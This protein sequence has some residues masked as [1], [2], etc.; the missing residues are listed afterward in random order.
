V[1]FFQ[2]PLGCRPHSATAP[3][4]LSDIGRIMRL[5]LLFVAALSRLVEAIYGIT[6]TKNNL[7]LLPA[8]HEKSALRLI[9]QQQN[10]AGKPAMRRHSDITDPTNIAINDYS[11][12]FW[13]P[14]IFCL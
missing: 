14:I 6:F 10:A 7:A 2:W 8:G 3:L 12:R 1:A 9:A 5:V 13:Q 11:F 4:F